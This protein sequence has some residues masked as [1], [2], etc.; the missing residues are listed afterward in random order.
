MKEGIQYINGGQGEYLTKD[1]Q[2]LLVGELGGILI[3]KR[4]VDSKNEKVLIYL[5]FSQSIEA[6]ENEILELG[7]KMEDEDDF[8]FLKVL[9]NLKP[10]IAGI[11][12][13]E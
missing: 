6:T 5:P 7:S 4:D 11:Y 12:V 10:A 3:C 13:E 9:N 1:E 2:R 8:I